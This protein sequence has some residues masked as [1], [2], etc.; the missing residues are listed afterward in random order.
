MRPILLLTFASSLLAAPAPLAI[1]RSIISDSE[2]GAALPK[3]FDFVPGETLFFS[4]RI[5]GFRQTAEEKIHL[6][7]TVDVFDP[8]G[9]PLVEH[10]KNEIVDEV[11][12]QD[13]EWMPK[14][15][16]EIAIPPLIGS[17]AYTI[18]VKA[19]DFIGKA[20]A[21]L[22]VP[23]QVRA[24]RVDRSDTLTLRNF[25]F[26]RSEEDTQPLETAAYR[27]GD[28]VW[29]RFDITGFKYGPKNAIDVGY[30][31]SILDGSG[32][33]LW[34]QP[35]ATTEQ[36]ESFYPKRYI[37]GTLSIT[38]QKNTKPGKYAIG[39]QVKDTVGTQTNEA[40][41]TFTVE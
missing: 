31:V 33:V 19:E 27:P 29:A 1:V 4:C 6:T 41:E 20:N 25:E 39:V 3:T 34:T 2:G 24:R 21:E 7:Y 13:K 38:I 22:T 17:G 15:A 12:P 35:E 5:S 36:S 30:V 28:T 8:A 26:L 14:I 23:F 37:S 32:K 9:V 18:V 16:T 11:G 40:K 10:F